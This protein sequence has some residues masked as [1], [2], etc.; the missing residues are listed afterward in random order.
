MAMHSGQA[1]SAACN[2]PCDQHLSGRRL[3]SHSARRG[4]AS[5]VSCGC[6][7][8][9]TG[10]NEDGGHALD[11]DPQSPALPAKGAPVTGADKGLAGYTGLPA[12]SS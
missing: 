9:A 7:A 8:D 11:E 2:T 4:S 5:P 1:A 6:H 10:A 3:P 12:A